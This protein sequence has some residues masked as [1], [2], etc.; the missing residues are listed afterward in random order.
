MVVMYLV[1][2]VSVVTVIMASVL[3]RDKKT[4]HLKCCC[5]LSSNLS[6]HIQ[7]SH[8]KN[9]LCEAIRCRQINLW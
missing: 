9:N 2:L 5:C 8:M 4:K 1:A 6:K 3:I 7:L